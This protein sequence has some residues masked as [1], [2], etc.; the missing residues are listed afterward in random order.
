MYI[1]PHIEKTQVVEILPHDKQDRGLVEIV[2]KS[3]S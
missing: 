3:T 2:Q 1:I